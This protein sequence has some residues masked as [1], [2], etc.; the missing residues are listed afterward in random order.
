LQ[1]AYRI[2]RKVI[3]GWLFPEAVATK[4]QQKWAGGKDKAEEK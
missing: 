1:Q 4:A 3:Q 2:G